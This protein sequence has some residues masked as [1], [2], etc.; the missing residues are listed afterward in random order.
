MKGLDYT[1]EV[2]IAASPKSVY[3]AITRNID[4]WWTELYT[5]A[6]QPGDYL[7]VCFE[8]GTCWKMQVAASEENQALAWKVLEAN[9][10][11]DKFTRKDEWQG[12]TI[13]WRIRKTGAG[14]AVTLIHRGLV[15]EL[16]C[17]DICRAGWA[18]FL[19]SLKDFLE[20]GTGHP[21]KAST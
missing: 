5:P 11:L 9:H 2:Q 21:Y 18:F 4:Q 12:T 15:P 3:Q 14:S 13:E 17:F 6:A 7:E 19:G 8:Q 16:E 1:T 20:T 10:E